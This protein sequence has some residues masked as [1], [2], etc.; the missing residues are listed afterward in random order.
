MTRTMGPGRSQNLGLYLAISVI[1]YSLCNAAKMFAPSPIRSVKKSQ[2][3][4]NL[5][6]KGPGIFANG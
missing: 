6:K 5:A 4:V 2:R 1:T 3:L